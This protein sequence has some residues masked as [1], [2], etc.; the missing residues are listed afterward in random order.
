[1][2][3]LIA[4]FFFAWSLATANPS[5]PF[6]GSPSWTASVPA[7]KP[8][9]LEIAYGEII[10]P[11]SAAS[12]PIPETLRPPST[13]TPEFLSAAQTLRIALASDDQGRVELSVHPFLIGFQ[14]QRS[15]RPHPTLTK[16]APPNL[17]RSVRSDRNSGSAPCPIRKISR[18]VLLLLCYA[19][20]AA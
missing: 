20:L 15:Q 4:L 12:R 10:L 13:P 7:A 5:D 9:R 18:H 3:R 11:P 2:K 8:L 17:P 19:K 1:M 6:G 14:P 16:C